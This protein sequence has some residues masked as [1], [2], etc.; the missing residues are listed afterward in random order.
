SLE[1][2]YV[3]LAVG[4]VPYTEGL[5]LSALGLDVTKEGLLPVDASFRTKIPSIFAIGDLIDGP[6]L[7]HKASEEGIAV[8]ELLAGKKPLIDYASIPNI[9]YTHPEAASVGL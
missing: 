6:M 8:A 7:A 3:L 5:G 4:R 9:I 2:D 1:G